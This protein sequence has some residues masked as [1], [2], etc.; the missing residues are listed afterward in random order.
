M[1]DEL[2][3]FTP[4]SIATEPRE[5]RS[6]LPSVCSENTTDQAAAAKCISHGNRQQ[7]KS[8]VDMDCTVSYILCMNTFLVSSRLLYNLFAPAFATASFFVCVVCPESGNPF[9]YLNVIEVFHF[10]IAS[11]PPP[12]SLLLLWNCLT[13][14]SVQIILSN[15]IIVP[16]VKAR[17]CNS[18]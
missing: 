13:M 2:G 6:Q 16:G 3:A 5:P 15:N 9:S 7:K 17:P 8:L 12:R 10:L 14:Q 11:E 1:W 18:E 4:G